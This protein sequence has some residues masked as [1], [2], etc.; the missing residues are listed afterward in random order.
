MLSRAVGM[1]NG[2]EDLGLEL[3]IAGIQIKI[4]SLNVFKPGHC[5]GVESIATQSGNR[6]G[7]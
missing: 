5:E 4:E 3:T 6:P 1:A 2:N 7:T